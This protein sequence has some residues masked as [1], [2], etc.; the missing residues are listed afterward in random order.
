MKNSTLMK[1]IRLILIIVLSITH[2]NAQNSV[3]SYGLLGGLDY[4]NYPIEERSNQLEIEYN[5]GFFIGLYGEMSLNDKLGLQSELMIRRH[6]AVEKIDDIQLEITSAQLLRI[7]IL[8][9]LKFPISL[10][11]YL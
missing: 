11:N 2:S 7:L 3:Y 9:K 6:K 1:F 5:L 10:F 4:F 8:L